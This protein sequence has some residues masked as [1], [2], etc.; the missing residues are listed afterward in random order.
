GGE[1]ALLDA[2]LD[3]HA[4]DAV[5]ELLQAPLALRRADRAAEVLRGDD[6][7]GVQRPE[8][9]ELH[10]ALLEV[11]RAVAPVGHDDVTTLPAHLVVRM[12]AGRG[13]DALDL[14]PFAAPLAAP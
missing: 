14:Q 2:G 3:V 4:D 12:H 10:T 11:D 1:V 8:V 5:D 6:V 7:D 9:G 13:E